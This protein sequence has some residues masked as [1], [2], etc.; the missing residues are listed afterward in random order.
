M[1]PEEVDAMLQNAQK[2][3]VDANSGHGS[4]HPARNVSTVL[5]LV[6]Q[7]IE[8]ALLVGVSS[9]LLGKYVFLLQVKTNFWCDKLGGYILFEQ[10]LIEWGPK[11]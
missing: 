3:P 6:Y 7:Q 5:P 10:I 8:K 1:R 9:K 2:S 11:T 4:T